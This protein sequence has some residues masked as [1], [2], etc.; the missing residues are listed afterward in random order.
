MDFSQYLDLTD[1]DGP[2]VVGHR[3]WLDQVLYEAVH[4]RRNADQLI[5]RFPTL[6]TETIYACLLYFEQNRSACLTRLY[7][8]IARKEANFSSAGGI[9]EAKKTE[10]LRR[11]GLITDGAVT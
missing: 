11:A 1:P 10:L 5:E 9:N 6:N 2:R 7:A 3:I 4:N 8:E